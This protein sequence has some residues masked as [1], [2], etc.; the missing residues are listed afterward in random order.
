MEQRSEL[1]FGHGALN[2]VYTTCTRL[3]RRST[4]PPGRFASPD[5]LRKST[6]GRGGAVIKAVP[7]LLN[8]SSRV[9]ERGSGGEVC[10]SSFIPAFRA[11][12]WTRPRNS[13]STSGA[14]GRGW[15]C[16][17]S[18]ATLAL[19]RAAESGACRVGLQV[20]WLSTPPVG[21]LR[22]AYGRFGLDPTPNTRT[23]TNSLFPFNSS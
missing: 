6:V 23:W 2:I 9:Q 3:A 11:A 5:L 16:A 22:P 1:L 21:S 13:F 20:I 8:A 18:S 17:S 14:R 19:A 15:Y 12:R 4:S 10:G 7:P